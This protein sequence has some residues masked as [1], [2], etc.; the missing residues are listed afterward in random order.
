MFSLKFKGKAIKNLKFGLNRIS[1]RNNQGKITRYHRGGGCKNLFRLIDYKKSIWNVFG[2]VSRIEYDPNRTSLIALIF[3]SNGVMSY[4]IASEGLRVGDYIFS[5]NQ[6]QIKSG[7]STKLRS[8]PLGLKINSVEFIFNRGAQYVRSAGAFATIVSK[9][10]R[11][12][13]LKLK[14]GKVVKLNSNCLAT[15]GPISNFQHAYRNFHKAGYFRLKGWLP[16]VRGV[17]MNPIDHPHGGGQGKTSGGRPS[18]TPWGVITKG[19]P[20]R[21]KKTTL[22]KF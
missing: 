3:Y 2:L 19:K 10:E 6:V 20:T 13:L 16:V 15:I 7:N 14:S 9:F 11:T 12:V 4:V 1:G 5:G 17:A 21:T 8:I 22:I 18:V